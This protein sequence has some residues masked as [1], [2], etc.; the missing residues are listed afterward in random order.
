MSLLKLSR[1][2]CLGGG[3]IIKIY[4]RF[5]QANF[6]IHCSF[7]SL[8]GTMFLISLIGYYFTPQLSQQNIF[9]SYHMTLNSTWSICTYLKQCSSNFNMFIN[10]YPYWSK[11]DTNS[12]DL[13]WVVRFYISQMITE[14]L[15]DGE[16]RSWRVF[17]A[18]S[19]CPKICLWF[20]LNL[21]RTEY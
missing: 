10:H 5:S 20:K 21:Q 4:D 3:S 19:I 17:P 14:L 6:N 15:T 13:G 8:L 9:L 7:I 1:L 12:V 11:T 18:S 2:I 16:G